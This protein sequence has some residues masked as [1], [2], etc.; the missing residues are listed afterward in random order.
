[1]NSTAVNKY[2]F[3]ILKIDACIIPHFG[4]CL[5]QIYQNPDCKRA[6]QMIS[7]K[8]VISTPDPSKIITDYKKIL[9][10]YT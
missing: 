1:M 9:K 5:T 3:H 8:I 10:V 2:S 6:L 4:P 7:G